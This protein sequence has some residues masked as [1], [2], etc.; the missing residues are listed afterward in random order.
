MSVVSWLNRL[1]FEPRDQKQ[2]GKFRGLRGPIEQAI[3][4][5]GENVEDAERWRQLLLLLGDTQARIDKN[6]SWREKFPALPLL[7]PEWFERACAAVKIGQK[8][9]RWLAASLPSGQ[10]RRTQGNTLIDC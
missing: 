10:N 5:I 1:P 7:S 6:K 4:R 9:F 2:K 3:V 8:S